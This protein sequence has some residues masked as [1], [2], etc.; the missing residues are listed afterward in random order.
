[1]VY[2]GHSYLITTSG[3]YNYIPLLFIMNVLEYLQACQHVL[4]LFLEE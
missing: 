3:I 4:A 1:M 2:V